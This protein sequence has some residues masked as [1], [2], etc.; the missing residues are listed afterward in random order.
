MLRL[1]DDPDEVHKMGLAR[2][3]LNRWAKRGEAIRPAS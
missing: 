3:K 1:A 2:R